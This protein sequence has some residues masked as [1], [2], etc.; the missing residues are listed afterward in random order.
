MRFTKPK[1][2]IGVDI[3]THSVKA[4]QM[5][6]VRGRLSVDEV[7][8][9]LIDRN[10][11]NVDPVE[12]QAEAVREALRHMQVGQSLIV[13]AL[14]GQTA[15]IRYPRLPDM[16]VSEIGEAIEAEAGQNIP[17][18][19]ADV[20]LDSY[21]LETVTE[22]DEKMLRVLL[23]AAKHDVIL[24]RV[25]IA[26]AADI[27]YGI[28]TVDSLALA[29]AAECCELLRADESVAL[30][31]IGLTSA[32]IHFTKDGISNF[33]RD[34]SWGAREFIQAIAKTRRCEYEQAEEIL[35]QLG[36]EEAK[37]G[38][39]RP[40]VPSFEGEPV[41][42]AEEDLGA[43]ETPT[44]SSFDSPLDPLEDEL[45]DMDRAPAG[46]GPVGLGPEAP[47]KDIGEV[48][49]DSLGRLVSEIRR[50]FDYY[51]H[52]LYERPVDRLVLCGGVAHLN[53]LRETLVEE[54]GVDSVEVADPTDSPLHFGGD[55]AT[56]L[57]REH[58]AQYMVALGLASRGM[59][60]L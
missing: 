19:L 33:I 38:E 28:L 60:D 1:K 24:S 31:D 20:F 44:L 25:Q 10:Q 55:S 50:S 11:V 39:E 51:E 34:V 15:V 22:G 46:P 5:S 21:P 23:V 12:A 53:L 37:P 49:S 35:Y 45:A 30:V 18:D 42:E 59:A 48:L 56:G 41:S 13:G 47:E 8:Y 29:D 52:Q 43:L 36:D 57:V 2:A 9:A 58:P 32:S 54:L 16:P 3:G 14:P 40:E 7:G 4:M 6:H 26:D 27:Q 17:Y